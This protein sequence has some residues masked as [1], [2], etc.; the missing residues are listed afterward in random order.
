MASDPGSASAAEPG[1]ELEPKVEAAIP[2]IMGSAV[3][4]EA[5]IPEI[6]D[7]LCLWLSQHSP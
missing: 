6:M 4:V 7:L 1:E 5:T 3:S 2:E